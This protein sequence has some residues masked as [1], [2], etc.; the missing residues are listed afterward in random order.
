MLQLTVASTPTPTVFF[1]RPFAMTSVAVF[2]AVNSIDNR[3]RPYLV[4]VDAAPGASRAAAAAQAAH[5]VLVALY[6]G[7]RAALDAA[8][9]STLSG[10]PQAAATAGVA[11]GAAAA[12]ACLDARENDGWNRPGPGVSASEPPRVLPGHASPECRRHVQSLP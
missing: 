10:L 2:D 7:Q 12:R 3:Y 9:S 6:P 5:D 4:S 1:T 11:V 8:L